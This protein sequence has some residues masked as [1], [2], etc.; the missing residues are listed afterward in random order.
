MSASSGVKTILVVED[1]SGNGAF[2]EMAIGS[3]TPYQTLLIASEREILQRIEEIRALKPALFILDYRLPGM[4]ATE[5]YDQ[6]HV[7]EGLEYVPAII[8]TAETPER[9]E[10]ETRQRNLILLTK[11]FE[12]DMLLETIKSIVN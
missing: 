10:Q 9:I 2:L 5:L 3:E 1:D 12:L 8:V 4:T 6:L 7:I 11:P